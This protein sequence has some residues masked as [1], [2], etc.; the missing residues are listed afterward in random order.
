ME[1]QHRRC[2]GGSAGFTRNDEMGKKWAIAHSDAAHQN[3]LRW[4]D[5]L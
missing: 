5:I 4:E 1:Q 2:S 3:S